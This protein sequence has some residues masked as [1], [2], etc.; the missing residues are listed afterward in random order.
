MYDGNTPLE[1]KIWGETKFV[2]L[3]FL[4]AP[5]LK[6]RNLEDTKCFHPVKNNEKMS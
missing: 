3:T 2:T 1:K 5:F 6:M 4:G